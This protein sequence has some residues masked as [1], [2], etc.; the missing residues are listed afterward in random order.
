LSLSWVVITPKG[1]GSSS[2]PSFST[3]SMLPINSLMGRI[4]PDQK[5][6]L[7]REWILNYAHFYRRSPSESKTGQV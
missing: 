2:T 7:C 1:F 6:D 3:Y 5:Q 4:F